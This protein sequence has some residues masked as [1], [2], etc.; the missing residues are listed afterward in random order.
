MRK[1]LSLCAPKLL[2][3]LVGQIF[4]QNV[5]H[6][7]WLRICHVHRQRLLVCRHRRKVQVELRAAI[8]AGEVTQHKRLRQL[9][10]PIS[11]IVVKDDRVAVFDRSDGS[12]VTVRD[13]R[14]HDELIAVHVRLRRMLIV[15]RDRRLGRSE[16]RTNAARDRPVSLF[17]ARPAIVAVHR[18]IAPAHRRHLAHSQLAH[19]RLY[20]PDV[21]QAV[22][23]GRIAPFR[24]CVEV[25][26]A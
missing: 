12:I 17:H 20:L 1:L 6:L 4:P 11:A 3:A 2:K 18:V 14:W 19:L 21:L 9:A 26:P 8:E 5:R 16:T 10:R 13:D 15:I 25:D 7:R 24:K 22:T 23:R